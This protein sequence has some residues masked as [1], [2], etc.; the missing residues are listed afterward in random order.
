MSGDRFVADVL[1]N[2]KA[3]I[4]NEEVAQGKRDEG[5]GDDVFEQLIAKE[6]KKRA[7]S[8]GLYDGAGLPELADNERAEAKVLAQYQPAQIS[9]ADIKLVVEK[10]VAD[11]NAG[12]QMMGQ[13][14]GVVKKSLVTQ[15][16]ALSSRALL[17][18]H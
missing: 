1:R 6:L 16:M 8:A 18:K 14:I 12:P 13:V 9:E 3:V 11:L 7:E 15:L 5:L 2:F 10:A 17:K 4:L